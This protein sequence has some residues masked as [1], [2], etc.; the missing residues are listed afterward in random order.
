MNDDDI[1]LDLQPSP[2]TSPRRDWSLPELIPIIEEEK[3]EPKI[4]Q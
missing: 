3:C 4:T 2:P 1:L